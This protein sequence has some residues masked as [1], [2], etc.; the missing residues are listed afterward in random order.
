VPNLLARRKTYYVAGPDFF[1]GIT[2]A[3]RQASPGRNDQGLAKRK[4]SQAV[5]ASLKRHVGAKDARRRRGLELRIDPN[6]AG[7]IFRRSFPGGP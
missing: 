6:R 3:L 4:R 7:K 2:A 1:D 5:R